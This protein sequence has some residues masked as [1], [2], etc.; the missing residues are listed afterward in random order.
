MTLVDRLLANADDIVRY[1][2][3]SVEA[4]VAASEGD[5]DG[6]LV[7]SNSLSVRGQ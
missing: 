5:E 7:T 3:V 1:N 2:I 6:A 4:T